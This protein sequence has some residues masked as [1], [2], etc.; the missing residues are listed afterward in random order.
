MQKR[1]GSAGYIAG[2]ASVSPSRG[3]CLV[4]ARLANFL[5]FIPS[6]RAIWV[7]ASERRK[8]LRYSIQGWYFS[9]IF[10]FF[11][12]GHLLT[13]NCCMSPKGPLGAI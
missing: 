1:P 8:R 4:L 6:F 13:E 12:T 2:S 10:F 11:A 3:S 7:W 5:G 9:G